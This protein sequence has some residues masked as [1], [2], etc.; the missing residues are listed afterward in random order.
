MGVMGGVLAWAVH[1][2]KRRGAGV[3]MAVPPSALAETAVNAT[4]SALG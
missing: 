4:G 1:Q 2:L 3:H